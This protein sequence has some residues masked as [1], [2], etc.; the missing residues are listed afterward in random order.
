MK[1]RKVAGNSQHEYDDGKPG[2]INVTDFYDEINVWIDV[3]V[4]YLNLSKAFSTIS[5]RLL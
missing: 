2:L 3:D 4:V 5:Y 1:D